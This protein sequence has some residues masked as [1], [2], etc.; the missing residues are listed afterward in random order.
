MLVGRVVI[1]HKSVRTNGNQFVGDNRPVMLWRN[2]QLQPLGFEYEVVNT[3]TWGTVVVT[4]AHPD[5]HLWASTSTGPPLPIKETGKSLKIHYK[6]P[7]RWTDKRGT[8]ASVL[9]GWPVCCTARQAEKVYAR[10]NLTRVKEDV[11]CKRCLKAL[12]RPASLAN[13]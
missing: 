2:G 5:D 6:G 9:P 13:E 10:G 7:F 8:M 3:Q 1:V 11:T 12:S 4:E